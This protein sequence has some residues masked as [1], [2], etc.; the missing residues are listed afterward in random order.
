[1]VCSRT[2]RL[3]GC[4]SSN[5]QVFTQKRNPLTGSFEWATQRDDYDYQQE[6]ARS[7]FADMLHDEERNQKYNK[8]LQLAIDKLHKQGKE[9]HVL[10]I[11]NLYS[12]YYV[13]TYN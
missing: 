13:I 5:M 8:A 9:A 12:I 1:M 7:A 3:F 6:I 4:Y 11:G 10:D 2:R